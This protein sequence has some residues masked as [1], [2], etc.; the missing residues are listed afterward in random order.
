MVL[1]HS[2][3]C[4]VAQPEKISEKQSMQGAGKMSCAKGCAMQR[5]LP[6]KILSQKSLCRPFKKARVEQNGN[7]HAA[8]Q[9]GQVGADAGAQGSKVFFS[10]NSNPGEPAVVDRDFHRSAELPLKAIPF[11][12]ARINKS[13]S[14]IKASASCD[15]YLHLR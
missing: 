15:K 3:T 10:S 8:L 9:T 4:L 14:K 6:E 7:G 12:S 13:C 1:M 2:C 11:Q 5:S